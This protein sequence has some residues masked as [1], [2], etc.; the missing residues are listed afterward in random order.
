MIFLSLTEA[1]SPRPHPDPTQ[2]P[3][4]R[5]KPPKTKLDQNGPK[6][7]ELDR[8]GHFASSL[9]RGTRGGG[10]CRDG[11]GCKRQRKSLLLKGSLLQTGF[12]ANFSDSEAKSCSPKNA[13]KNVPKS[14]PKN[15]PKN[16]MLSPKFSTEFFPEFSVCVFC[17][18]KNSNCHR[19]TTSKKFSQKIHH[20]A[21][22]D[23]RV[24]MWQGWKPLN[25]PICLTSKTFPEKPEISS[26][27]SSAA[28]CLTILHF[29][30]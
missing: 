26:V 10:V 21:E 4:T 24:P 14:S 17:R 9:G 28:L 19:K 16:E 20:S 22:Q 5:Q 23:S 2:H 29:G 30:R 11:G 13:P 25:I 27:R 8:I 18:K 12:C 1:P 7:T 6:R 15:A 3:K